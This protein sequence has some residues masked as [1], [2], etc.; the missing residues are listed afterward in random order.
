MGVFVSAIRERYDLAEG[1]EVS[2]EWVEAIAWLSHSSVGRLADYS[3]SICLWALSEFLCHTFTR[4]A[5][6]I[7]WDFVEGKPYRQAL[8]A[9]TRVLSNWV[10]L[11]PDHLLACKNSDAPTHT[12]NESATATNA[13]QFD[14]VLTDPPYYDA[15]LYSDL[16]DFFYVWH[17]R[18]LFG[19]SPEFDRA[20]GNS[21]GPKWSQDKNDGELVDNQVYFEGDRQRSKDSL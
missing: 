10:G 8:P 17:R 15:I 21:L 6:P 3:S 14:V 18:T 13:A 7:T 1:R 16:M 9:T 19:L 4:F 20:F 2:D 5:L 11:E 12:L